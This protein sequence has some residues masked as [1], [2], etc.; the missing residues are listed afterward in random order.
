MLKK[1][2]LARQYDI[3]DRTGVSSRNRRK[4]ENFCQK[5]VFAP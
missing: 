1:H 3:D 4:I 2:T 5:P